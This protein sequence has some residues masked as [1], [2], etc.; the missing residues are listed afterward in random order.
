MNDATR[1]AK[2]TLFRV[3]LLTPDGTKISFDL[4]AE[5]TSDIQAHVRKE[6]PGHLIQKVKVIR[7]GGPANG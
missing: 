6:L 4:D 7:S 2:T 3:H 1:P 5:N